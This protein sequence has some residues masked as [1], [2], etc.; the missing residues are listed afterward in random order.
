MSKCY[1]IFSMVMT[2]PENPNFVPLKTYNL[3]PEAEESLNSI[4]GTDK[5]LRYINGLNITFNKLDFWPWAIIAFKKGYNI[6]G[7]LISI[8]KSKMD[9]TMGSYSIFYDYSIEEKGPPPVSIICIKS[10]T[11]LKDLSKDSILFENFWHDLKEKSENKPWI[12]FP[13]SLPTEWIKN[14]EKND[15]EIFF[16]YY[17]KKQ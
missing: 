1:A 9:F 7:H 2:A 17:N 3:L 14:Q 15:E 11:V 13:D 8:R 10:K 12:L 6:A 4:I 5:G 16:K